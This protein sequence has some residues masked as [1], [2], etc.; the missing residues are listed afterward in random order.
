MLSTQYM[1][2]KSITCYVTTG[3]VHIKYMKFMGVGVDT[4]P[5]RRRCLHPLWAI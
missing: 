1:I 3:N 2:Y 5:H 4:V